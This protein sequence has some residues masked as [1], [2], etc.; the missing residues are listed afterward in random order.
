MTA[1]PLVS[2]TVV[3]RDGQWLDNQVNEPLPLLTDGMQIHRVT[4]DSYF[5]S[6]A[7]KEF[8]LVVEWRLQIQIKGEAGASLD[9]FSHSARAS[10]C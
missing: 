8:I 3:G 5:C 4:V 10:L 2:F 7:E 1:P 9:A 6:G